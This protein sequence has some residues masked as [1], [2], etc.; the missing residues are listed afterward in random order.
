M[1]PS[2]LIVEDSASVRALVID[3]L[4]AVTPTGKYFEACDGLE[5][6]KILDDHPVDLIICDLMMP[7]MDG[8]EFLARVKGVD[9]FRETP[10]IILSVKEDSSTK[11]RM[12]ESGASDYVTKPFNTGEL[13]ARVAVQLHIK[14]L[15]DE[16][17]STNRLLKEL[18][19]TDHLTH[20]YNRRYL[21]DA[22]R[23]EFQR[24]LRKGKELCLVLL[25]VDNFKSIN[26]TYGHQQGDMV[27]AAIAEAVQVELRRYDIAARYGGEEFAML[28]P[29]TS[30]EAGA[31]VAERLRQAVQEMCFPPPLDRLSISIS[32]GIAALPAPGIVSV[33]EMIR[34]ADQALYRA[35]QNGRNR[36]E[37]MTALISGEGETIGTAT[38]QGA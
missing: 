16:M 5:G 13:V 34:T 31:A 19:I 11:I 25:D 2:I 33:D 26:D 30:L 21:M 15:Q 8:F 32:Q 4:K 20:L 14:A 1:S 38:S 18:S 37:L 6:L 9:E 29:E 7:N 28:L 17:R 3:K 23:I 12:L 22:L 10:V 36:V 35:K 27:L 24:S